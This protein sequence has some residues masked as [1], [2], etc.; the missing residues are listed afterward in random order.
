MNLY[1]IRTS[2]GELEPK[3]DGGIALCPHKGCGFCCTDFSIGN[4]IVLYPGE[5]AAAESSGKTTRHLRIIDDD[6]FGG[7]RAV[8]EAKERATCDGGYK[9][10]DCASYP[11]FPLVEGEERV[12]KLLWGTKCPLLAEEIKPHTEWVIDVWNKLIDKQPSIV[13]W[14]RRV[15]L[16]GYEPLVCE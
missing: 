12:V 13:H 11:L 1:Q 8:C 9:P 2:T 6:Y 5:L 4:F 10:L 7:A 15:R 3:G 14:L 16:V